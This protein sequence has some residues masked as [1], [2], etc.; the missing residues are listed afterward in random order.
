MLRKERARFVLSCCFFS[1]IKLN[2]KLAK[3]SLYRSFVP[4]ELTKT[5]DNG[6]AHLE[7]T[8]SR[9]AKTSE[10]MKLA[11]LVSYSSR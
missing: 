4:N 2:K 3:F 7:A 11:N 1:E 10:L 8:K 5:S 6:D 9:L